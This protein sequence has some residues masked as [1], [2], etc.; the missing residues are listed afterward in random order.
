MVSVKSLEINKMK[1]IYSLS[2]PSMD[3]KI[4]FDFIK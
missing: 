3:I 1:F 4:E 2:T